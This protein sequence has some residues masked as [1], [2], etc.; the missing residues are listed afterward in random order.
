MASESSSIS[1]T[2]QNHGNSS[3][4]K[5]LVDMMENEQGQSSKSDS[6]MPI[7]FVKL[8]KEDSVDA[9]KVQEHNFFSP[10]QVGGSSSH[11]PNADNEKKKEKTTGE[12]NS[13]SKTSYPCNFCNREYPTLQALGGHQNAHKTERALQMQREQR[14][15]ALG[16]GQTHLNPYF[17][18]P[19]ALS[20][21]Y[22]SLGVRMSSMIQKP[23]FY[24]SPMVTPNKFAY[25]RGCVCF[26]ETLNPSL[27]NLR[28]NME[29]SSRVGIIGLG[30]ATSSRV[31]N[32]ANNKIA[33][34]L[35]LGES[36][37][38][39]ATSSNS[40]I[41]KNFFV[42]AAPV[43]D[44]IYQPEFQDEIETEDEPSDSESSGLDLSL[45]L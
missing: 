41:E 15:G 1:V 38:D 30:G 12:K 42:D 39:V 21:P 26:Q 3:K 11:S 5:N 29:G 34:F 35:K 8:S 7:D 23:S 16:L 40:I 32:D 2:S 28:N 31:E 44:E 43:K 13:A 10:I 36:S 6:N 20:S 22:G 9:S 25:G 45:K 33:S 4:T 17:H 14:Y 24:F 18:Y 19:S 37:K 27:V